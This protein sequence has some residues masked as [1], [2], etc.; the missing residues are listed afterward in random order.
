[1]TV[2]YLLLGLLLPLGS[3]ARDILRVEI[4]DAT[5][6]ELRRLDFSHLPPARDNLLPLDWPRR[7]TPS[8]L[9]GIG[10]T[11]ELAAVELAPRVWRHVTW[12]RPAWDTPTGQF[13]AIVEFNRDLE[14]PCAHCATPEEGEPA[15]AGCPGCCCPCTLVV[16]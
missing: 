1:M 4:A 13:W 15:H 7:Q 12:D 6:R 8:D 9:P 3:I 10:A 14:R 11:E 16:A 2:L 5:A